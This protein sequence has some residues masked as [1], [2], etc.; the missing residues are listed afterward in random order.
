MVKIGGTL[1]EGMRGR[2]KGCSRKQVLSGCRGKRMVRGKEK[3]AKGW[4]VP[5]KQETS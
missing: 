3:K 4:N 5:R 2:G 1:R